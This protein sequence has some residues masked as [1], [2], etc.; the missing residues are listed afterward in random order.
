MRKGIRLLQPD[1]VVSMPKLQLA[2]NA[3][4]KK[5]AHKTPDHDMIQTILRTTSHA[6][7]AQELLRCRERL[8]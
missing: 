5:E 3:G 8:A 4:T 6:R 7:P 2:V 1:R